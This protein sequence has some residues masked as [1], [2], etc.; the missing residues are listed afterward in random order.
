MVE[1]ATQYGRYGYRRIS[2][3][4]RREGWHVNH[5]LI[6]RLWRQ[7]GLKV[8]Q[9]QPKRRR[10]WLNDGSCIRLRPQYRVHVWTY[11]FVFHRTHDGRPLR[12]L[13]LLD[14][15][16]RECL[17]IDVGRKLNSEDV[18]DRLAIYFAMVGFRLL[19]E[20][21]TALSLLV[22]AFEPG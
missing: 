16:S 1:L 17:A 21:T 20:A 22:I 12:L 10:L 6:E 14:E 5:K 11:D 4:L 3:L 7:E 8:P 15:Y 2:E 19:S 18:L 9:R 13:T